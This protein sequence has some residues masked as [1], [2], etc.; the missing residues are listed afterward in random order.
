[1]PNTPG[2]AERE[3][4]TRRIGGA[5]MPNAPGAADAEQEVS[6]RT[7]FLQRFPCRFSP[8]AL[9]SALSRTFRGR[10]SGP[11]GRDLSACP[12]PVRLTG[13]THPEGAV[14]S[15]LAPQPPFLQQLSDRSSSLSP[16]PPDDNGR[17]SGAGMPNA[18]EQRSGDAEHTGSG[19]E[20]MPNAPDRWSGDAER[21]GSG[22]RRTGGLLPDLFPPALSLPLF[23]A[24][25]S[26]SP[27]PNLPGV[28]ERSCGPGPVCLLHFC[29]M[30]FCGPESSVCACQ[31]AFLSL[32]CGF[33]RCLS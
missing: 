17:S 28:E 10:K 12:F 32:V 1:M 33:C 11:A 21:A 31:M 26:L 15:A 18:P 19:G 4:R 29:N 25:P 22:G 6:C 5:G 3:C 30:P 9:P 27:F 16:F 7:F 2:A 8:Q 13:S 23:P 20:G 14:P 24:S